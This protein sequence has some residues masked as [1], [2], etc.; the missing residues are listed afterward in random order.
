MVRKKHAYYKNL[1]RTIFQSKA[2]FLSIFSIVFLGAAFFAGLRNT[3]VIMAT[4]MDHYLDDYRFAD[5]TYIATLGFSEE[6]I[7]SIQDIKGIEKIEYGYQFDALMK[8]ESRLKGVK[9]YT[10][11]SFN[12]EMLNRPDLR[13]GQYPK[14]DNEC[15]VDKRFFDNEKLELN[16]KMTLKN[17]QGEKEFII[18]GVVNDPRY[19]SDI[20]RGTNSLGDGTNDGYVEIL[21]KNNES[22]AMPKELNDLRDEKT[23]YNQLSVR[24]VGSTDYQIFSESYDDFIDETNIKIKSELSL[25]MGRLYEDITRDARKEIEDA[26]KEYNKAEKEFKDNK[27]LFDSKILEAKIQLA[28]AK[29]KLAENEEKLLAATD[30]ASKQ[31][32]ALPGE[33]DKLQK[34]IDSLKEQLQKT[35]TTTPQLP[36]LPTEPTLP[37]NPSLPTQPT[38]PDTP[39]LPDIPSDVE[40]IALPAKKEM[41]EVL[42]QISNTLGRMSIAFDGLLELSD[43]SLQIE[44]AKLEIEKQE[45]KLTLEEL[46]TNQE[47]DKAQQKLDEAQQKIKDAKEQ[48]NDIPKGTVY[49]LT[50]NENAGAVSFEANKDSIAAIADIFPLMF[51]LVSALVSLTTMTRMIEEQRGQSGVL[52]ALGYSKWDVIKQYI[53]YVILATFLACLL[54]ILAGVQFLPRVIYYLYTFMMFEVRAP[55]IIVSETQI[56]IQTIFISVIVTLLVTLFVCM[57][58][59][60]LMPSVLM[61]PKAP[62]IGKRIF[63][64]RITWF[65]K[66]LS[67]N[68]KVTLRNIFRYKKR[69]FMSIIGIAGCTALIITGFGIKESVSKV[70]KLQYSDVIM[71]DALARLDDPISVRDS[72]K[73][74]ENLL[75]RDEV[76]NAEY[77]YDQSI[78][79]LKNKESLIGNLV[80]YQSM[81]NVM[82][83]VSFNDYKT[84]KKLSLND[85]GVIISQK[86]SEL[87]EIEV[88]DTVDIE[89]DGTKYNIKVSG[90]MKNYFM[91]YIYMSQTYY[92]KLTDSD[93]EV[94]HAFISMTKTDSLNRSTL[95]SYMKDHNYG[96]L[97]YMSEIGADFNT[98]VESVNMVVVILIVCAG[99]LNFIV[100]YNLTNINVQE[101]KTEIATIKVLGFR[102]QE[103][104]DY[105][106]RENIFLSVIGSVI[107]IFFGYVLHQFIIRTVELDMTMFVRT[108]NPTSYIY[109]IIMTIG[110]TFFINLTM[111]KVLNRVDMV[112]SLKSIE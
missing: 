2:R 61:R 41:I 95:E 109:A 35:T 75:Q 50:R 67:F 3:P 31:A 42:D 34:Q 106:F 24:V 89:L 20:D 37:D 99:A 14:K 38:L 85:E 23:L 26:E 112:E 5:L 107:G 4:S 18:V 36:S 87:L 32:K 51:F 90:I 1:R 30:D 93:L 9:V 25:R 83:F 101:R 77:V 58:E 53:I 15:I 79:I 94:N 46:K 97:S 81:D 33:I 91:N 80:V 70:V 10:S 19:I 21:T 28:N 88:N 78:N 96:S 73:Y 16:Q 56:A 111:R 59:L 103:V 11:S 82:N 55:I 54:G 47:L 84:S 43:A 104:Y 60:N 8:S 72:Q 13:S 27:D 100:L 6:D 29:L 69:F 76:A 39:S 17:D 65:W 48:I 74:Q 52:R 64:E 66:K 49:S 86:A 57:S 62:K 71:Y 44:K 7:Q 45:N 102:R 40:T 105:V 22:L 110:F 63:L 98:Q 12:K 108:L 68:H 92:E